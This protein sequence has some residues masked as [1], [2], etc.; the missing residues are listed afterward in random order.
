MAKPRT[1][2]G[3]C[4]YWADSILER[5]PRADLEV[6]SII[7]RNDVVFSFGSHYPMGVIERRADGR[8][9]CVWLTSDNYG[10][11]GFAN[12]G[13]DQ[14]SAHSAAKANAAKLGIPVRYSPM[15]SGREYQANGG[16]I[17]CKPKAGDPRPPGRWEWRVEIPVPYSVPNPGPEPTDDGVG[18]TV[19]VREEYE[20]QEEV[21]VYIG[22]APRD[23]P[24][25]A[26]P[27]GPRNVGQSY[28]SVKYTVWRTGVLTWRAP[29]RWE[30]TYFPGEFN[31]G[32]TDDK[33]CEHCLAFKWRHEQWKMKM[34]GYGPS[35]TLKRG[36]GYATMV[37][38]LE[39]FGTYEEWRRER[40][41]DF[42][43]VKAGRKAWDEWFARNHM[44]VNELPT[45]ASDW[46][47]PMRYVRKVDTDGRPFRKDSEAFFRKQ[48]ERE[49]A[50]QRAERARRE[51]ERFDA[52]VERFAH[53]M[54]RRRRPTFEAV[55]ANVAAELRNVRESIARLESEDE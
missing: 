52:Q 24:A 26:H 54:R 33:V 9:K 22:H 37:E 39:R 13:G 36:E 34:K 8:A 1:N 43:R 35:H 27:R 11:R 53:T 32:R 50:V 38:M 45:L 17:Q 10:S 47:D 40:T 18:C 29:E 23:L 12:T 15:A 4:E 41:A 14:W 31:K 5:A 21:N 6:N 16:M 2:A 28:E 44:D 46:S 19:G 48:R 49:R 25:G 30:G 55:A 3:A 7:V 42:R 20:Y 51:R